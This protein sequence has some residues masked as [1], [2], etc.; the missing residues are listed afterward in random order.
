MQ[1][2][3]LQMHGVL[4]YPFSVACILVHLPT[5]IGFSRNFSSKGYAYQI[6]FMSYIMPSSWEDDTN[7][8]SMGAAGT[9][10]PLQLMG[11]RELKVLPMRL[12]AL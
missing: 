5:Q 1:T 11:K 12:L 10:V 2:K 8:F 4:A 3:A 6:S 9:F 7:A